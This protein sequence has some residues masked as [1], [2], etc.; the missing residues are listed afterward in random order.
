MPNRMI[1]IAIASGLTTALLAAQG[2]AVVVRP[3]DVVITGGSL[4]DSVRDT[5]TPNTALVVRSGIFQSVGTDLAGID[6]TGATVVR[7]SNDEYVL[8][9]DLHAHYAIDLFANGRVDE[10]TVNPI[11]FLANGV[12]STFPAGEVDPEGMMTARRRIERGEQIGPRIHSS[13]PYFG[14]ARP[15]W[16]LADETPHA[17]DGLEQLA[18]VVDLSG[19]REDGSRDAG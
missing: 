14:S 6:L 10:Y 5:M 9:F 1:S 3:G 13:G 17:R 4:F 11:V 16:R 2:A 7:L 12:T 18:R 8:L 19:Q 15:G